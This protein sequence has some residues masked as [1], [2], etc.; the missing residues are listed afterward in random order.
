[1][2][3]EG[4][5]AVGATYSGTTAA[6]ANGAIIEGNVGIG[7]TATPSQ[8][9]R[10][11]IPSTD[12]LTPVGLQIDNNYTG[13]AFKYGIDVNVDGAGSG[14]K[15]GISSSVAGLA[16]DS[17]PNYGYQVTMTPNGT[18]TAFGLQS[19]ISP[20]GT[21]IRYGL[22]NDVFA[23]SANTSLV[24]GSF[25]RVSNSGSGT[26]YV[27]YGENNSTGAG[28]DYGLY[29]VGGLNYFSGRVGI[30]VL[31][32][33]TAR[34]E[35]SSESSTTL[36]LNV[37]AVSAITTFSL[38]RFNRNGFLTGNISESNGTVSYNAFTGS[39]YAKVDEDIKHGELATLTGDNTILNKQSAE[40][41]YGIAPSS[42]ENDAKLLGSYLSPLG[43]SD[44]ADVHQVMAV[45][46]GEV[47]VMHTGK[48]LDAG[49]YLISS[50]TKG[51]AMQENG[52]HDLA[53]VFAR[54]A[55]PVRWAEITETVNGVRHTKVSVFYE[56]FIINNKAN[57][58]EKEIATIKADLEYLKQ[59]IGVQAN[60]KN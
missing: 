6:P 31:N 47:W 24:Y 18:G 8:K 12:L 25:N 59:L 16:G 55:A 52:I 33:T 32:P 54:V 50:S 30:G 43:D 2:D 41:V 56:S 40:L 17:S 22:S 36:N 11:S 46:N 9:L 51:H 26:S 35:V 37:N 34:L 39:H 44:H 28:L 45:G 14:P 49:D 29:M 3:V 38:V 20:V 42:I 1:L 19:N 5:L 53:Y 60:K 4:G 48:D 27:L 21:G 10:V 23:A 7:T 13:T 15:F 58:L 57:K